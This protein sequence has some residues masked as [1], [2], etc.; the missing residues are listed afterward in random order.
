VS[1]KVNRLREAPFRTHHLTL[2]DRY[3]GFD[4][5]TRQLAEAKTQLDGEDFAVVHGVNFQGIAQSQK[6][7]RYGFWLLLTCLFRGA[8]S[9][10]FA[11][12][13]NK[14]D[15]LNATAR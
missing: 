3:Q 9:A 12:R 10:I 6:K 1:Q 11:R 2:N 5:H 8:A 13:K 4:T 15:M 7:S 14:L